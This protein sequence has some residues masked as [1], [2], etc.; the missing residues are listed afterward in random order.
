M[1][2]SL[3]LVACVYFI[4]HNFYVMA[5]ANI[6]DEF[7]SDIDEILMNYEFEN[8]D[9]ADSHHLDTTENDFLSREQDTSIENFDFDNDEEAF[10]TLLTFMDCEELKEY[11]WKH[12][13][14]ITCIP[15]FMPDGRVGPK[16][17]FAGGSI[18]YFQLFYDN[19]FLQNI[20]D[21]TNANAERK[22]QND[23]DKHKGKWQ[24]LCVEELKAFLG[25][26]IIIEMT[27]TDRI[28]NLWANSGKWFLIEGTGVNLVFT[29]T[30]YTQILRYL[31]F[32]DEAS[33]PDRFSAEYD[34]LY[35]IR[36]LLDHLN[37][38]FKEEY[39]PDREVAIDECMVPFRGRLGFKQ[40]HKDKPIKW[41]IKVWIMA[42]SKTGYNYNFDVYVGKEAS[43][44][45][46][47][48][49]LT[50]KVVLKLT[51][52]LYD[53]GYHVYFDRFYTSPDLLQYLQ[54]VGTLACGTVQTNRIGFPTSLITKKSAVQRGE[55][56][57]L[58][59][60]NTGIIATMWCDNKPIY[61]LTTIHVA[62][63]DGLEVSRR[64]KRGNKQPVPCTPCVSEYN[65]NMGG[66]DV[67]D[68][69]TRLDKSRRTYRWYLR[70]ER[71]CLF[72]AL[73]N[74]FILQK[75]N[76]TIEE[77]KRKPDFRGFCYDVAHA[78]VGPF[79]SRKRKVAVG[80]PCKPLRITD[81]DHMPIKSDGTDHLCVVCNEKYKRFKMSN[82]RM[83]YSELPYKRVKTTF[84]CASNHC[85]V[86]LCI[87]RTSTC[88][89]DWHSKV[90]YW[91]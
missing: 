18:D 46:P 31:H 53:K 72:W 34:K 15:A 80:N 88:W 7:D 36:Y 26:R 67:N 11:D 40:Y 33:V 52:P 42:E 8:F 22:I 87:T 37:K 2:V 6:G 54:L 56:K 35:K 29:R 27:S 70:L 91:R 66:V 32:C 50:S 41:G 38:R 55:S 3:L 78:L 24:E 45:A 10:R 84:K 82:P 4:I 61:F 44:T 60:K 58:Q 83:H 23:P 68:K 21:F 39:V 14:K 69:M 51:Q 64:D 71:K 85:N 76:T 17:I 49:G 90:Q 9:Y 73:F 59:C 79:S 62:E 12:A 43:E 89:K 30:R 25:V 81:T 57:W 77:G 63:S 48:I 13:E 75:S 19:D 65:K 16:R 28:E 1:N 47:N 74:G 86:H 5:T 20:C